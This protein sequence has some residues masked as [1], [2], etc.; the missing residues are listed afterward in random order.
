MKIV[1]GILKYS[2]AV[3]RFLKTQVCP[4]VEGGFVQ[5]LLQHGVR[6]IIHITLGNIRLLIL[7]CVWV[8]LSVELA[9]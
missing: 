3:F 9:E 2:F 6:C 4:I 7:P 8:R 1:I 5:H